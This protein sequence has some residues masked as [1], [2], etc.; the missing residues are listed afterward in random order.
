MAT[1]HAH[2]DQIWYLDLDAGCRTHFCPTCCP[3]LKAVLSGNRASLDAFLPGWHIERLAWIPRFLESSLRLSV[4]RNLGA[5]CNAFRHLK[6]ISLGIF[7]FE[8]PPSIPRRRPPCAPRATRATRNFIWS[9]LEF[10]LL[11]HLP[12][13]Q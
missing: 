1:L 3:D 8:C 7:F 13:L 6:T 11:H 9:N 5:H 4:E 12:S 2:Q 10:I